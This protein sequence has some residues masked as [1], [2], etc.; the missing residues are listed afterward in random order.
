MLTKIPNQD[1]GFIMRAGMA[2]LLMALLSVAGACNRSEEKARAELAVMSVPYT[3][4]SFIESARTGNTA[5]VALFVDSGMDTEVKTPEGQT[6]LLAA[7]LA[8]QAE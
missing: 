3:A 4:P 8:N 1:G 5:A 7:S 2:V 6:P